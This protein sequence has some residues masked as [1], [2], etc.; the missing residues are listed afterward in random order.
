MCGITGKLVFDG[1]EPIGRDVIFAMTSALGHRG[2]DGFGLHFGPGLGLG[3]RRAAAAGP[4]ERQ[5]L[6]NQ[7]ETVWVAL[8][9]EIHNAEGLRSQLKAHGRVFRTTGG[10][11]VIVQ[12]YEQWG[13]LVVGRLRGPFAFALWDGRRRRLLLGRDRLGVRP[14]HYSTLDGR[15]LVF[16]SEIKALFED[17]QVGRDWEPAA[18]R[19]YMTL[20]CVPSPASVF[21][22][23]VKLPPGHLL[24]AEHGRVRVS[25]YW[26]LPFATERRER[27]EGE[28][29][30]RLDTL[31]CEVVATH[32]GGDTPAGVMLSSGVSSAAVASY[33]AEVSASPIATTTVGF[34]APPFDDIQRTR[35]LAREIGSRHY[36][37]LVTP[38]VADLLPRLVWHFDEPFA[39]PAAVTTYYQAAG[40]RA[41]AAVALTAAGSHEI[42][43][44]SVRHRFDQLEAQARRWLG[45]LRHGVALAGPVL[46]VPMAFVRSARRLALSPSEAAARARVRLQLGRGSQRLMTG[47]FARQTAGVDPL[48]AFRS[49]Y[50]RCASCDGLDRA[51]YA[52][53][54]TYL[55][56]NL[57]TTIDR[58]GTAA[59]LQIRLPM[60]DHEIVEFAATVPSSLKVRGR[61]TQ[62]LLGQ[63]LQARM[64]R[65]LLRPSAHPFE[66]MAAAWLRGPLAPLVSD[67]LLSGRFRQRG[68][69]D[70]KAVTRIW[71]R[72]L[73]GRND[74]H[75]ELWALLMLE[76]W[77]ERFVDR[78]GEQRLRAA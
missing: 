25:Q 73:T 13:D 37:D 48:S 2:P 62:Y 63:L 44:G 23:V 49:R 52:D 45:P 28:Y 72:H 3:H 66:P 5:P 42:W 35:A 40:A 70:S 17:P 26:E 55:V 71:Q 69:F 56:D 12:G 64:P 32:L 65:H 30:E 77:F 10:A 67:L 61:T 31:L 11:E 8:D 34:D 78:P 47:D 19:E 38:D 68:I 36:T 16:A 57:L 51:L 9:G 60:L 33:A 4:A 7:D 54:N 43:A 1:S 76:L 41:H 74:Y 27:P 24:T 50:E 21:R 18:I 39:D 14:L 59:S 53:V 46:P 29:L 20:G 75:R 6:A 22:R 58:T 15:G